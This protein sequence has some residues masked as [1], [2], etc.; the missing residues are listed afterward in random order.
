[1]GADGGNVAHFLPIGADQRFERGLGCA[2]GPPIGSRR[3]ADRGCERHDARIV[4]GPQHGVER[5][6]QRLGRSDVEGQQA[7]KFLGVDRLHRRERPQGRRVQHQNVKRGPAPTDRLR[8][9]ADAFP[10]DEVERRDGGAAARGMDALLHFLQ[11]A[12]G[13]GGQDDMRAA[14]CQ[15]FGRRCADAAAG[16]GH[17]REFAGEGKIGH[18]TPAMPAARRAHYVWREEGGRAGP[19][20]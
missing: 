2:I 13:A 12:G 17:Q 11:S 6:D 3:C 15:C 1:M 4:A 18:G 5:R 20:P 9:A 16:A 10:V 8:Q 14:S 7:R 19:P